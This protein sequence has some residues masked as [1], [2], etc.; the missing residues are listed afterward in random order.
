MA[1]EFEKIEALE[2]GEDE[3][4]M[5]TSDYAQVIFHDIAESY[6]V[7]C[8]IVCKYTVTSLLQATKRDWVRKLFTNVAI[9][10]KIYVINNSM[11][12]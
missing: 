10:S 4:A 6:P 1:E 2:V 5:N 7:D 9:W 11:S 3:E 8:N 12:D